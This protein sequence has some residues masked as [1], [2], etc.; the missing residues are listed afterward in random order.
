LKEKAAGGS[1]DGSIWLMF[2]QRS[3]AREVANMS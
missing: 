1:A 3:W 2:R